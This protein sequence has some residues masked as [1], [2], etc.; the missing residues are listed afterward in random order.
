MYY[1]HKNYEFGLTC[2]NKGV[3]GECLGG[4]FCKCEYK[5]KYPYKEP[6]VPL[7]RYDYQS[8]E[9]LGKV[10]SKGNDKIIIELTP[11]GIKEI[12]KLLDDKNG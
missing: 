7:P 10:I 5:K 1:C 2:V 3:T 6:V 8:K 11:I 4:F 12:R 9:V